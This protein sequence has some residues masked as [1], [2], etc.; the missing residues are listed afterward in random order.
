MDE[1]ILSILHIL[2]AD[3]SLSQREISRKANISLGTVNAL[4]S[5]CIRTGLIKV[6]KLNSR[7]IRYILTCEGMK[8]LTSRSI[9]YIQKSYQA[10]LE[11]EQK[12]RELAEEMAGEGKDIILLGAEDEIYQ[13]AARTLQAANIGF[14]HVT[15]NEEL[16]QAGNFFVIYW[17]PDY[18]YPEGQS[19]EARNIF[20][21]K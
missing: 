14:Q 9:N 1:R 20:S 19:I 17:D 4:I 7:K 13:I 18:C 8:E 16:P 21:K 10:I 11:M 15:S 2:E 5:Q 12:V 6:K 3:D